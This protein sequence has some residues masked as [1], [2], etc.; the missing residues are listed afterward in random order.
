MS[1]W[2]WRCLP[3]TSWRPKTPI[4][5]GVSAGLGGHFGKVEPV[6]LPQSAISP[7]ARPFIL[8]EDIQASA[9]DVKKARTALPAKMGSELDVRV[10][11]TRHDA[12]QKVWA[13]E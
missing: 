12:L 11:E 9:A 13:V 5:P 4:V 7:D 1:A 10:A 3:A 8:E 2:S 6:S